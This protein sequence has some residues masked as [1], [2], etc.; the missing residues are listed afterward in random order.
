MKVYFHLGTH[1]KCAGSVTFIL[2]FFFISQHK[3]NFIQR[4]LVAMVEKVEKCMTSS[5]AV[6]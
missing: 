5:D 1:L 3:K 2:P 6:L 4:I